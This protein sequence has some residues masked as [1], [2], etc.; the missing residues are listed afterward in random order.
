M[1]RHSDSN[2]EGHDM[3]KLSSTTRI[4]TGPKESLQT[5]VRGREEMGETKC[6]RYP[7][8]IAPIGIR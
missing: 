1:A 2:N 3:R 6:F 4:L 7:I 8:I 5:T